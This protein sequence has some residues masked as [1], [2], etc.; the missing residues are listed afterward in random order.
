MWNSVAC[1]ES[2]IQILVWWLLDVTVMGFRGYSPLT[3]GGF[4][5]W[6]KQR[7]VNE[8]TLHY[9][10]NWTNLIVRWKNCAWPG[11][12]QMDVSFIHDGAHCRRSQKWGAYSACGEARSSESEFKQEVQTAIGELTVHFEREQW[13]GRWLLHLDFTW[14]FKT[15]A[16]P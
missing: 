5:G 6:G 8:S 4:G 12:R 7:P 16:F 15:C 11:S 3:S 14:T 9:Y 10:D 2:F 13:E 1:F